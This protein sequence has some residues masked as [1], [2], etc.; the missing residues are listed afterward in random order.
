M[1][2]RVL[3]AK[4]YHFTIGRIEAAQVNG[5]DNMEYVQR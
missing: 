3:D 4:N 1:K 5:T 2:T